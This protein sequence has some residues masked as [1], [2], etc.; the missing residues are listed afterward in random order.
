MEN[1]SDNFYSDDDIFGLFESISTSGVWSWN[2]ISGVLTLTNLVSERLGL[3]TP[4]MPLIDFL[5]CIDFEYQQDVLQA[6]TN[7]GGGGICSFPLTIGTS[8]QWIRFYHRELIDVHH[9]GTIDLI[10]R[11]VTGSKR[12]SSTIVDRSQVSNVSIPEHMRNM[13]IACIYSSLF[14]DKSGHVVDFSIDDL[15]LLVSGKRV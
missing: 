3:E 15:N 7:D 12:T 4:S 10:P 14:F 13:P 8:E 6:I 2:Q 1:C 9:N 5:R 11:P